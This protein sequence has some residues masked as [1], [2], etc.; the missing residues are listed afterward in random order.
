[1]IRV[2]IADDHA[3]VRE[4]LA[5]VL[6]AAVGFEVAALAASGPEALQR[7]RETRAD[8]VLLDMAMPGMN[9]MEALKQIKMEYPRLPV[10]IL[11]MYPESQYAI[12]AIRAGA[13]GYLTKDCAKSDLLEALRRAAAGGQYLTAA[14]SDCLLQEVRQPGTREEEPHQRLSDREFEVL[15]LIAQGVSP[16]DMARRLNLSPKTVSTYRGRI[17]EKLGLSSNAE[18]MRYAF[19]QGIAGL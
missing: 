19:E 18:L 14:V 11:S 7:I 2:L 4:G 13:A 8:V 10:L 5:N 16:G 9:G 3:I 12:R 17:L 6:S 15:R 1:M